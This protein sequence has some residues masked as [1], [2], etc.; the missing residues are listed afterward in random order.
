MLSNM[1]SL[2]LHGKYTLTLSFEPPCN[3]KCSKKK[4]AASVGE[5]PTL[6][7]PQQ[8]GLVVVMMMM[9][10]TKHLF[11][12]YRELFYPFWTNYSIKN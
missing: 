5:K 10:S 7:L 8:R 1:K 9:V 4:M 11:D 3:N 2:L 12:H 6:P